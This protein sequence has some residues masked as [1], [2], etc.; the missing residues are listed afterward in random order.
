MKILENVEVEYKTF[1]GWNQPISDCRTFESLPDNAKAYVNFI[2]DF[3]NVP[4]KLFS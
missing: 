1:E 3:L 2:Q 4:S